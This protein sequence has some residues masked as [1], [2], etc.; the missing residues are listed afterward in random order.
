MND[1]LLALA[2]LP[3]AGAALVAAD[4]RR[5]ADPGLVAAAVALAAVAVAVALVPEALA[6]RVQVVRLEWVPS[7]G[8]AL[9]LRWDGLSCLLALLVTGIGTLVIGYSRAYLAD[10]ERT[11]RF[12]ALVLSFMG[13]MLGVVLAENL[14][15]LAVAWELTSLVSFLLVGLRAEEVDARRGARLAFAI[16]GLGGLALLAGVVLLGE[17]CGS[18]DLSVVLAA[19]ETLAASGV[20][21]TVLGL[22]LVAAFTK[23]AQFPW[24]VWLPH[25]MAAPTPVSAYLHSATL[26][27]AGVF[28]LLRLSPVLGGTGPWFW[29]VATTGAATLLFGSFV[30]LHRHDLKGLLAYS[31]VSHL[32][33]IVL[34][35]GL[36]TPLGDV[37]AIFH[38]VNH[39]VFKASLFMAAGIVDHETGTR[40]MRRL[41]GL[42]RAMPYTASLAVVAAA[43]MAGV[44]L[45]NGFL[46]KEMFFA[47]TLEHGSR[48]AAGWLFPLAA[49]LAG[50]FTVAYSTRFVH[51]VFFGGPGPDLG[52][53]VHEAPRALRL[54]I[55]A[56]VVVCV[57]VGVLPGATVEPLLR[58]AAAAAL[59]APPPPFALAPWHGAGLPFAMSMLALAGGLAI[60]FV[61]RRRGLHARPAPRVDGRRLVEA[62]QA[63]LASGAAALWPVL[64][65]A[66]LPR[67]LLALIV[68]AAGGAL[69]G[70]HGS[71]LTGSRVPQAAGLLATTV[72]ALVA[73]AAAAT[74]AWRRRRATALLA[75]GAAGL[76][77]ALLFAEL[78]APDLVLTQ[79]AVEVVTMLLVAAALGRLPPPRPAGPEPAAVRDAVVAVVVGAGAAA[80]AWAMA[81]RP[82]DTISD[83]YLRTAPGAGGGLNVV[84]VIL[85]DFRGFDT[86]GEITVLAIAALAVA[87]IVR[88]LPSPAAP[89]R[90]AAPL[91]ANAAGPLLAFGLLFALHLFLR[92]HDAPGGGF[93]AG[94]VAALALH[95]QPLAGRAPAAAS[96]DGSRLVAAGLGIALA[97]ALGSLAV[98]H[99]F[100]TSTTF[101]AE[102]PALGRV[103][104]PSATFFDLGVFLVVLG[105]SQWLL[106]RVA[107][108]REVG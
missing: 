45:L 85:V 51:D 97:T 40:D 42:A 66:R 50:A 23:S 56:L 68:L 27:K 84:N 95:L 58:A 75:T 34:L 102:L 33:L 106:G 80:L 69:L 41:S 83:Y 21:P 2:L 67:Y 100:L 99:P 82:A 62:F 72:V 88:D 4:A 63:S 49:T 35:L 28:L 98:D 25:A 30:A 32:G 70:W 77:V 46:S 65:G 81:T 79:L 7:L 31:T 37:A 5:R 73:V 6:G 16:T 92:G 52:R 39:A 12:Y 26:V 53:E 64:D 107:G 103:K 22:V 57:L 9:A 17:A 18:Y 91:L 104:L 24:H 93:V 108:L 13:A 3:F 44:P 86:L 71:P 54:P 94:L 43:A 15:Q 38:L 60:Y 36:G 74:V 10:A 96:V 78:S 1:A 101:A 61:R 90:P 76:G 47:E 55:E 29:T 87:A 105:T 19:R 89:A 11:P 48:G 59:G 14:L 8:L 20:Y